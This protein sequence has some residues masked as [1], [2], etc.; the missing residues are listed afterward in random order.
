[1]QKNVLIT[2]AARRI[3]ASCARLLHSCGWRVIVHFHT[4]AAEAMQLCKELNSLRDDSAIA[5]KAD[6]LNMA[7]LTHLA[8]Q[9]CRQWGGVDALL[10]NAS[11]FTP[12]QFGQVSDA[13]WDLLI[14]SN[15]KAPF[16]L[17]QLLAPSL[18]ARRGCIVNMVDIH[19]ENGLPNY[20]VYSI[21]KAGLVTMTKC[22]ARELA[23]AV[24]VNAI[25]PGAIFWPETGMSETQ[26]TEILER[27]AL[28]RCGRAEEIARAV[29]FL[30]SDADYITGHILTVDG[31][32]RLFV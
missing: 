16:F 21:A 25:A 31:G 12:G 24:R 22:L 13:D 23:P 11:Q 29:E 1:M 28:G 6:L 5:I 8:E 7:E 19:A 30:M 15:L 3:G 20:P 10:N 18:T 17:A 14:N 27:I 2:G 9:S 26:K 4:S 32:R